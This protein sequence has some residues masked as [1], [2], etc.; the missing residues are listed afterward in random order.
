MAHTDQIGDA[1]ANAIAAPVLGIAE[2]GVEAA[3][4]SDMVV[5]DPEHTQSA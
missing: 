2:S 5:L 1:V 4:S 3:M